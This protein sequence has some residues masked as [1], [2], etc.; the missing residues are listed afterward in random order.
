MFLRQGDSGAFGLPGA[1]GE[2]VRPRAPLDAP[3]S[4][5]KLVPTGDSQ[6]FLFTLFLPA[7]KL[8]LFLSGQ[9][10]PVVLLLF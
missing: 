8:F 1:V 10:V 7:A 6:E 2:K 9:P 5:N 4:Q 3:D